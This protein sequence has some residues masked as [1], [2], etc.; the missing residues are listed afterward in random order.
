[1]KLTSAVRVC[2]ADRTRCF[3]PKDWAGDGDECAY[4]IRRGLVTWANGDV[5]PAQLPLERRLLVGEW[6]VLTL[7][8]L[9]KEAVART[10]GVTV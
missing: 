3:R 4:T 10:T 7:E 5:G 8:A 6:E 1:M 2:A 9:H